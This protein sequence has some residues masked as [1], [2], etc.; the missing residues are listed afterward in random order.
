M[1]I[2][3]P[4]AGLG[5]RFSDQGYV[6]PKPL[7]KALGKEIIFWLL[8]NLKLA[9]DDKLLII[10]DV[11]MNTWNLQE[12]ITA[13]YPSREIMF[14]EL[15]QKTRGAAETVAMGLASLPQDLAN[16]K[17]LLLDCDT[18][19]TED[20]IKI[21]K[22]FDTSCIFCFE[23]AGM[24]PQYSYVQADGWNRVQSIAEKQK[25]SNNAC[26]GAY[27]FESV[28]KLLHYANSIIG[29]A[30]YSS[31]GEHYV[32]DIY[33][34]MLV[35][36]ENIK[37]KKVTGHY[38]LGTPDLVKIFS[39]TFK[40]EPQRFCFDID[41]TLVTLPVVPGDYSTCKPIERNIRVLRNL[42]NQGH[43]IILHTARRM[44][45]HNGD[46]QKVIEDIGEIT[47]Q[48]MKDLDI[49]YHEIHFGKPWC[50]F[51]IDDLAIPA[52]NNIEQELGFYDLQIAPRSFNTLKIEK[53]VVRKS[54]TSS[55]FAGE[56]FYFKNIP[57]QIKDLFPEVIET[58]KTS[59]TM[60]NIRGIPLS[61][62]YTSNAMSEEL[63]DRCFD[64][65]DRIHAIPNTDDINIYGN[66]ATKVIKRY[67][68]WKGYERFENSSRTFQKIVDGLMDYEITMQGKQT[69]IHGDTVLT[70]IIMDTE[71]SLK[72]IDM[73]GCI[74]KTLT[75]GGDM[76]Y[77]YAKFLQSLLGYD[78]ILH[79][80]PVDEKMIERLVTHFKNRFVE[81]FGQ[82][83]YRFLK[84]LTASL[85]FSL[86]PLHDEPDKQYSYYQLA[87]KLV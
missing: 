75:L 46:V 33:R 54:S 29:V 36:G 14:K 18:F 69:T 19:H 9:D 25:I 12:R 72:F 44:R 21:A 27:M 11:S 62:L 8:D 48:S 47:K 79:S 63:V 61:T 68:E 22:G 57:E 32:S 41:K 55:D 58:T 73:R 80:K 52:L 38:C 78:A 10:H 37:C 2:T 51:Y 7:V 42:Y 31:K 45:T 76:F 85:L 24:N 40:Q 39:N 43:Y 83:K 56:L 53:D 5:K 6:Y 60:Q 13:R 50:G 66:Y 82:E 49:P 3:I 30:E 74:G 16:E 35:D 81:R 17:I 70:N 86:I 4:M 1:I 15:R 23:D 20:I 71:G 59:I 34:K 28:A 67:N 84:T 26:V 77:D 87:C 64:A 65:F